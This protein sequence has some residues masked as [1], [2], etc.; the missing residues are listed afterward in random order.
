MRCG[1]LRRALID[2]LYLILGFPEIEC[3]FFQDIAMNGTL[4][5]LGTSDE[6]LEKRPL[7][8]L[9]CYEMK[10]RWQGIRGQLV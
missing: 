1:I 7:P 6:A 5:V 8:Q 10:V 4:N 2:S 9:G 3:G